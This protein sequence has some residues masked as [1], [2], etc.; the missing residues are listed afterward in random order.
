[1]D[2]QR[3][4][5]GISDYSS[6]VTINGTLTIVVDAVARSQRNQPRLSCAGRRVNHTLTQELTFADFENN[7]QH[8]AV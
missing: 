2:G 6:D 8:Y 4:H 3:L 7:E 5:D 1:M